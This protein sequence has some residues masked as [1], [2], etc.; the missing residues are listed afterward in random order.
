MRL[1]GWLRRALSRMQVHKDLLQSHH[2]SRVS[3]AQE[4][5]GSKTT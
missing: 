3:M 1:S 2:Y 4:R 5:A